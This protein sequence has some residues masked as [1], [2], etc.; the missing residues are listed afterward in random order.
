MVQRPS[1]L[2]C[3]LHAGIQISLPEFRFQKLAFAAACCPQLVVTPAV[4][5][6]NHIAINKY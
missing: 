1:E 2:H 3:I 5:S 6:D 4:S